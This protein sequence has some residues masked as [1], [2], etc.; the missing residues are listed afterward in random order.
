MKKSQL[1]KIVR[2]SIKGL[3]TEQSFPSG[4]SLDIAEAYNC[5]NSGNCIKRLVSVE[6][7]NSFLALLNLE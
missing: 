5:N 2:E 4:A 7:C 1:R 3:I 6:N